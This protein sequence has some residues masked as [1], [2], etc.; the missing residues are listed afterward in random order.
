MRRLL[1]FIAC[2]LVGCASK[3]LESPKPDKARAVMAEMRAESESR[4]RARNLEMA[5]IRLS[6]DNQ[7]KQ[8]TAFDAASR[9][10]LF[11]MMGVDPNAPLRGGG[12]VF[13]SSA[14]ERSLSE[15]LEAGDTLKA[16][17]QQVLATQ[18][19]AR[20]VESAARSSSFDAAFYR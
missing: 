7:F 15:E 4:D 17:Q 1:A 18:E 10:E 6:L 12:G 2:S 14:P 8:R 19:V 16:Q 20:A 9:L 11:K 3:P 5:N 13:M